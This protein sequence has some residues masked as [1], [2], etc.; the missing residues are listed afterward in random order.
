MGYIEEGVQEFWMHGFNVC[1]SPIGHATHA[2]YS[3]SLF[4]LHYILH[5]YIIKITF[6]TDRCLWI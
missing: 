3:Y 4:I 6:K 5:Y 2:V 1:P